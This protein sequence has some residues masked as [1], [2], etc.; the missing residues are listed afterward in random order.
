MKWFFMKGPAGTI[1]C[2]G[3]YPAE[4]K[5]EAAERWGCGSDEITVTGEEP[6]N[7]R[8]F[9][10]AATEPQVEKNAASGAGTLE[11]AGEPMERRTA[12]CRPYGYSDDN[13]KR[14]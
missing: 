2:K 14:R 12:E 10:Y 5:A 1:A 4:A 11:T 6:Y 7:N 9:V 3:E 8:T 13:T